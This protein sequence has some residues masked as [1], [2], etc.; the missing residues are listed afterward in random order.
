M[1][2]EDADDAFKLQVKE[3]FIVAH[4]PSR[5][6]TASV[7]ELLRNVERRFGDVGFSSAQFA[8]IGLAYISAWAGQRERA[9]TAEW[10][11]KLDIHEDLRQWEVYE[12]RV[13]MNR[14]VMAQLVKVFANDKAKEKRRS[15]GDTDLTP[16]MSEYTAAY[17]AGFT[18]QQQAERVKLFGWT[19]QEQVEVDTSNAEGGTHPL[20][21]GLRRHHTALRM[22]SVSL[23]LYRTPR[24]ELR[25]VTL[26]LLAAARHLGLSALPYRDRVVR[27]R[28]SS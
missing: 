23:D 22:W 6:N 11:R 14:Y 12:K 20:N 13:A 1:R 3:A 2:L 18:F 15:R 24:R 8:T 5:N 28:S 4:G 27:D 10:L 19:F 17:F 16:R 7:Q 25:G 26:P 9:L 21:D